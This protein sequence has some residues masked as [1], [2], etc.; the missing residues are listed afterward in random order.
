MHL[1]QR[2][3]WTN[4]TTDDLPRINGNRAKLAE[5]LQ[6]RYGYQASKPRA[7]SARSKTMCAIP[8]P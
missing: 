7:P 6:R 1:V 4:L 8:A 5:A 3:Y 2:T